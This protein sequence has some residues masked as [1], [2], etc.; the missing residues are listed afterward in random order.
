[1]FKNELLR[2]LPQLFLDKRIYAVDW[3]LA[4][5][6]S[7]HGEIHILPHSTGIMRLNSGGMWSS[8]KDEIKCKKLIDTLNA[9]ATYIPKKYKVIIARRIAQHAEFYLQSNQKTFYELL[10][11]S[12]YLLSLHC[13]SWTIISLIARMFIS[14]I[15]QF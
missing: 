12:M 6:L 9:T 7:L 15:R 10:C 4:I 13:R 11:A 2:P 1:M 8:L 3:S 14:K 5:W